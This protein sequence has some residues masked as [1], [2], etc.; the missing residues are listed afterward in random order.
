M[1]ADLR[2]QDT[3]CRIHD[4]G[5]KGHRESGARIEKSVVKK[6]KL[7]RRSDGHVR[8]YKK[9]KGYKELS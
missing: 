6:S 9:K 7:E 3:R 4:A 2:M 1:E 8:M 5:C